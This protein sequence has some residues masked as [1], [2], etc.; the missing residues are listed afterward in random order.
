M[1]LSGIHK[2]RLFLNRYYRKLMA[3][4]LQD[5]IIMTAMKKRVTNILMFCFATAVVTLTLLYRSKASFGDLLGYLLLVS[6]CFMVLY[7]FLLQFRGGIMNVTRKVSFILLTI[8]LIVGISR[9]V[10]YRYGLN[11]IFIIPFAIVP[12]IIRTFFDS[13]LALFVLLICVMLTSVFLTQPFEFIFTSFISGMVSIYT[14]TSIY[15]KSRLFF[16]AFSVVVSMIIIYTGFRLMND[17]NFQRFHSSDIILISVNGILTLLGYPLIL[18]FEQRFLL[19]SETTLLELSDTNQPLLRKLAEEAPGSFQHSLQVANLAEEA[20]RVIGANLLLVRAGSMYHDIGKIANPL[21]FIENQADNNPH[22]KLSLRDSTKVIINHV[23]NGVNLAKNYKLPV[24]IIDFIRTHHGT[25]V[26]Y[27]FYK[28]FIDQNPDRN[29]ML[30][31][32]TYPGPK[33]FSKETAVVMMADAVEAASRTMA[34]YSDEEVGELVDRIIIQ[35][36]QDGQFSEVPLTFRDISE[37][38]AVFRKR[39]VNIY[40]TRIVYPERN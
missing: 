39:L 30:S 18:I 11:Y 13:K 23:R 28:K 22:N 38:K 2:N 17:G 25:T 7:L 26:A 40:H 15:R 33:P 14:L 27:Y 1:R 36:E 16:T 24:Q 32:F 31:E 5:R 37:I 35:Q 21:Y 10:T 3:G 20:A 19:I 6:F 9:L 4:N 8:I 34:S 29:D 12:V